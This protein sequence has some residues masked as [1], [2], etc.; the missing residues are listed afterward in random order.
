MAFVPLLSELNALF[1]KEL[2]LNFIKSTKE[3]SGVVA[4]RKTVSEFD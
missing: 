4:V 2:S 1:E 3:S